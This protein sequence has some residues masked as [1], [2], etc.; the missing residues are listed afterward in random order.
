MLRNREERRLEHQMNSFL[1][2]RRV[3][4]RSSVG[5]ARLDPKLKQ[6]R[7]DVWV[8]L[9]VF[10]GFIGQTLRGRLGGDSRIVH[11]RT[12]LSFCFHV[13]TVV[14]SVVSCP[15]SVATDN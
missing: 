9:A 8:R 15:V 7:I 1:K 11:A 3:G 10:E 5:R 13:S 12:T 14:L 4:G 2:G 6:D